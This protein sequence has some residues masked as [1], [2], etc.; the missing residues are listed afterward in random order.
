MGVLGFSARSL[1]HIRLAD[2]VRVSVSLPI[3]S[4]YSAVF[5]PSSA[6]MANN[7]RG[8]MA[9]RHSVRSDLHFVVYFLCMC[10]DRNTMQSRIL[11]LKF[12]LSANTLFINVATPECK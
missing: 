4:A 9:E 6:T 3:I 7:D 5:P 10:K 2:K 12:G 1:V 11:N 8:K